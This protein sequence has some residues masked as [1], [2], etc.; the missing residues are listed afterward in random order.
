MTD[1]VQNLLWIHAV[2][3]VPLGQ[4]R[5][6]FYSTYFLEPKTDCRHRTILNLSFFNFSVCKTSFK[7]ETLQ[8]ITAIMQ[9]DQWMASVDLKDAYFHIK[10]EASHY[11]F[12]RFYWL[13]KSYQF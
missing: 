8:S 1:D 12:L 13:G 10:V 6:G 4:E 3:P 11:R 5:I 9:P 2:V 7:M